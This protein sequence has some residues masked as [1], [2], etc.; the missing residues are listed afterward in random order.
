MVLID[1]SAWIATTREGG[2]ES[3]RS[4]VTVLIQRGTAAW[5]PAIRLELW[6]G[7]RG[8]KE[9]E[10]LTELLDL[11]V[12]L[13]MTSAVWERAIQL[14]GRARKAGLN[15]PYPDLLISACAGVHGVELLHHDKHLDLLAAL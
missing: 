12:D 4:R 11:V 6:P 8:R 5:C 1:T 15:C 9:V 13:K 2:D 14:A 3:M 10:R 7:A